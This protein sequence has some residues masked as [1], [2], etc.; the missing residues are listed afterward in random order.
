ML[1][2]ENKP[3][4]LHK[5]LLDSSCET[6]KTRFPSNG[7]MDFVIQLPKRMEFQRDWLLCLKSIHLTNE[8]LPIYD[9]WISID[10]EKIGLENGFMDT[11]Q[12]LYLKLKNLFRDKLSFSPE[13]D[14]VRIML[15]PKILD[16]KDT[17]EINMEISGNLQLILGIEFKGNIKMNRESVVKAYNKMN[18]HA[19]LPSHF[20]VCCDLVES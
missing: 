14:G 19:L 17:Q 12:D 2:T 1:I 16:L 20:I 13:G 7:N 4:P 11:A 5:I 3:N 6:S 15:D 10:G 9:C 8:F 18:I